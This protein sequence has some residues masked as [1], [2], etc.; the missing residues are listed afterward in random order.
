M[1]NRAHTILNVDDNEKGRYLVTRQLRHAG[2]H[3]VEAATGQ[4]ALDKVST[5]RPDLVLLDV[6]LPD[7]H[8][9]EVCR[10]IRS[11][12]KTASTTVIHLSAHVMDSSD[13]VRGLEGG[14]DAYLTEPIESS[15]LVATIRSMLRIREAEDRAKKLSQELKA[16]VQE[17]E[18]QRAIQ[19]RFVSTLSHDLRGPLTAARGVAE[20]LQLQIPANDPKAA[21]LQR[22]IKSVD[23]AN[24]MISNLL[25]ANQLRAGG[26]L[27]LDVSE[28]DLNLIVRE[29]VEELEML[30][31]KRFSLKL[32]EACQGFWSGQALRRVLDNLLSNAL[33]YG[34]QEAPI[35][36][37]VES[38]SLFVRLKVCNR[39]S[40][41][42]ESELFRLFEAYRRSESARAS[43]SP[44]WG[45]GLSL[46]RGIAIAHGG[47]VSVES[48]EEKGTVFTVEV[49]RDS[50][51]FQERPQPQA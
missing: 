19:E 42:P 24:D 35:A 47:N 41:I 29:S 43:G 22:V 33:K 7:I 36:I 15:E 38:D 26:K 14:A 20:L 51:P 50:R 18:Q 27:P 32:P 30:H 3:V 37:A 13:K 25:D 34:D 16:K 21:K 46:V 48:S 28:C 4:E 1:P 17:L 23:R 12:P 40:V 6:K 31:G 10:R 8:G 5:E 45:L 11:N 49:P 2:F 44:G 39:G 9:F